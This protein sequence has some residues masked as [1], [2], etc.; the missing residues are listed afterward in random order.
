L[1]ELRC[2]AHEPARPVLAE[3]AGGRAMRDRGHTN[4][5]TS[6]PQVPV[7]LGLSLCRQKPRLDTVGRQALIVNVVWSGRKTRPA[8]MAPESTRRR[9]R[10]SLI[11]LRFS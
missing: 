11:Y 10:A 1:D 4:R 9:A 2:V 8:R 6:H 7:P 3:G 5:T